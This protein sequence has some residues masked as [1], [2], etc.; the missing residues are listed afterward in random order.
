MLSQLLFGTAWPSAHQQAWI[1]SWAGKTVHIVTGAGYFAFT[2]VPKG[3]LITILL[4]VP[5]FL[6]ILWSKKDAIAVYTAEWVFAN[7]EFLKP[8][9]W[10]LVPLKSTVR[11][12]FFTI[13]F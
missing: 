12:S 6:G 5:S 8:L 9:I 1:I 3:A 7:E 4:K 10:L 2:N 11:I 13:N